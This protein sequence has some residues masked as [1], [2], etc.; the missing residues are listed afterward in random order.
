MVTFSE[1]NAAAAGAW[2]LVGDSLF[3]PQKFEHRQALIDA[4]HTKDP[5]VIRDQSRHTMIEFAYGQARVFLK[6]GTVVEVRNQKVLHEAQ[7]SWALG[8]D[9][10][11]PERRSQAEI[12]VD[13]LV[14]V[15]WDTPISLKHPWN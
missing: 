12:A 10:P 14:I 4:S 15:V 1:A 13:E 11:L 3:Y 9:D 5:F 8:Q 6:V 2:S 7:K